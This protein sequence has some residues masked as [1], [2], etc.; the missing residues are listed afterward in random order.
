[1]EAKKNSIQLGSA[2]FWTDVRNIIYCEFEDSMTYCHLDIESVKLYINTIVKLCNGKA[3][4]F[5]IDLRN[6]RF[7]FSNEAVSFLA[8]SSLLKTLIISEVFILNSIGTKLLISAYKRI[9]DPIIPY[10]IFSDITLAQQYCIEAK[11][12]FYGSN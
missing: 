8:Q 1:M 7:T 4:P 2:R 9:F 11:N 5:L 3:M 6:I 12:K 10:S